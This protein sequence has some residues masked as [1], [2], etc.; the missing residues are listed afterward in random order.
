MHNL[1]LRLSPAPLNATLHSIASRSPY[2]G[3]CIAPHNDTTTS[4]SYGVSATD[5][6]QIYMS[7]TPYNDAFEEELDLRK[8][9]FTLHRTAGMSFIPQ[10]TRLILASMVPS[11]PGARIPRWRTR[12]RG[13]WLLSV[14]GTPVNSIA[15]VQQAFNSLSL[16]RA[17]SCILLFAH[18]EISHGISNRGLPLLSL[19]QFTQQ[20]IDQL[21]DRWTPK[22]TVPPDLPKAPNWNIVIDG[23]IR[24]VVTKAM[25]LT[26]G[27]LMT[28][29]DWND[30]NESEHL[31]LD[32]YNKQF[33]F[34]DPVIA[35]DD[36]AIFHLVWTL[37]EIASCASCAAMT[38]Q[39]KIQPCAFWMEQNRT[40]QNNLEN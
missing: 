14:D 35:E 24:N 3:T 6:A 28:Q 27:K 29:D 18:P 36:S 20:N 16:S 23:D 32:Q 5:V 25:K 13:A 26:R 34:G 22:P 33:M 17:S 31:Q 38:Y 30:W 1:P 2:A 8:F 10:D 40:E 37:S 15:S 7:P 19:D 4:L 9:N 11:T 39:M 21:S 12:L